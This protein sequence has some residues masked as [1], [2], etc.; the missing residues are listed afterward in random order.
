MVNGETR[1][2]SRTSDMVFDVPALIAFI[3]GVMT[4]VPGDLILTGT[5]SGVSQVF[6]G[7][8]VLVE[9]EGIGTLS[10]PVQVT[11]S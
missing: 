6:A 5:P 2:D 9:I 10:S 1:Q 11:S 8:M 3:S 4:L 7:D